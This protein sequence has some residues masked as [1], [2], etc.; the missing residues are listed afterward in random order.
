MGIISCGSRNLILAPECAATLTYVKG[1]LSCENAD[2]KRVKIGRVDKNSRF[3]DRTSPGTYGYS[4][5]YSK[6]VTLEKFKTPN[7]NTECQLLVK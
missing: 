3:E 5:E 2:G 4:V 6:H 7:G 1:V